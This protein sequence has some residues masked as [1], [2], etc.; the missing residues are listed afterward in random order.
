MKPSRHIA[1]VAHVDHGQTTLVAALFRTAGPF[2]AHQAMPE[3]VM[4][5]NAQERGRGITILAKN[6]AIDFQGT[7]INSVD[8]PGHADFGGQV[9]RTLAMA[10]AILLLV[11]AFE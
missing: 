2:R 4:D 10:D 6:T 8:T 3:R 5:T 7:R 9:A 1:I 11:D